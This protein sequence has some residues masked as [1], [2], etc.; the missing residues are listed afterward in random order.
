VQLTIENPGPAM[1][2][3]DEAIFATA[4]VAED[5]EPLPADLLA[6]TV[7]RGA[8]HTFVS[9]GNTLP[10]TQR[11]VSVYVPHGHSSNEPCNLLVFH[12]G[13]QFLSAEFQATA[14]LDI[15]IAR[16]QIPRTA[17]VFIDSG[18][19]I[20]I[21]GIPQAQRSFEYDSLTDL[22]P[23]LVVDEVLPQALDG[24]RISDDPSNRAVIGF[25]SGAVAA[26][27]LAW[28]RPA[29]FGG[30]ISYCGSFVNMRSSGTYASLIRS[31]RKRNLRMFLQSGIKDMNR[32]MG[33]WSVANFDM[34]SALK[35]KGYEY[36]FEFGSGGHTLR[37]GAA[38]FQP[39]LRWLWR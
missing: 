35:F 24:L 14:Q 20:G 28:Q 19:L 5:A 8:V 3:L 25:S 15:L 1:P 6:E 22:Y 34:A 16:G 39:T 12:D 17:A 32:V 10:E 30:V 36:R 27:T 31:E 21:Q 23:R 11:H 38:I 9:R 13:S 26:L 37:H 18:E 33:S 7:P 4:R 29:L 2:N